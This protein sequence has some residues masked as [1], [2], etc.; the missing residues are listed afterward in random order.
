MGPVRPRLGVVLRARGPCMG[1][2]RWGLAAPAPGREGCGGLAA[3]AVLRLCPVVTPDPGGCF[4]QADLVGRDPALALCPS[5]G[6]SSG[7]A[8][9]RVPPT[10]P[11]GCPELSGDE[12]PEALAGA[13]IAKVG[14]APLL[15]GGG[16]GERDASPQTWKPRPT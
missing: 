13:E 2:E 6:P 5:F 9:D 1:A 16:R 11:R 8:E 15:A 12:L 7:V 10:G 14:P 3:A 4:A